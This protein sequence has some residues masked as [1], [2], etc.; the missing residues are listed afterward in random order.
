M[1]ARPPVSDPEIV[2][3]NVEVPVEAS[4]CPK[5]P[6]EL[7]PS[8]IGPVRFS[9][10]MVVVARVE[11]PFTKSVDEVNIPPLASTEK[12]FEPAEF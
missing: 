12:I 8:A 10:E 11:V 7:P 4:T 1:V 2:V 5:I 3:Q 9:L 6:V